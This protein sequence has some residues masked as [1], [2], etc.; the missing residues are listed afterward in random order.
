MKSINFNQLTLENFN[1]WP[2]VLRYSTV[3]ISGMLLVILNYELF[4]SANLDQSKIET[5]ETMNLKT[6]FERKQQSSNLAA[7][8][9]QL[10]LL[11]E[12]YQVNLKQLVKK[13]ELSTLLNEISLKAVSSG[14][15]V[16]FFSPK[17]DESSTKKYLI[18]NMDLVGEYHKLARFLSNL[19]DFNKLI[20]FDNFEIRQEEVKNKIN[21]LVRM[22]IS[23]KI[24]LHPYEGKNE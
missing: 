7:Y 20:T 21:H 2:L 9:Q 15:F 17:T 3:I 6:E 12:N 10:Q 16:E 18:I 1:Q 4:I 23:A 11:N 8:Q 22:K 24:Y 13:N 19:I 5:Y 14:L